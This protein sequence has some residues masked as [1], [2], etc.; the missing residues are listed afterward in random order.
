MEDS[1]GYHKSRQM[2]ALPTQF[3]PLQDREVRLGNVDS[4]RGWGMGVG[5]LTLLPVVS[6]TLSIDRFH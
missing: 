4:M 2:S 6:K 1:C 3:K 5:I